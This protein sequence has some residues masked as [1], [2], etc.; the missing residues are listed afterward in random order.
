MDILYTLKHG[1]VNEEL[2]YSLRSLCNLPHDKV[3]FVGGC[4][5]NIN[6]N[7]IIHIP[8]EQKSTKWRNSTNNVRLACMDERLSDDFILMNDDFF[9]LEPI[10]DPVKELNVSGG[11]MQSVY[12]K[13]YEKYGKEIN[14]CKGMR[15]TRDL[16]QKQGIYNPLCYELHIPFIFNKSKFLAIFDIPGVQDINVLHKRSLYGNLHLKNTQMATDVKVRKEQ[17]IPVGSKFI[18]CSDKGFEVIKPILEKL[19]P[20]KSEYEQE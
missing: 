4:P 6:K 11:T 13:V 18:S 1:D 12:D 9:I 14:W 3:F 19:F 7:K 16:L 17:E 5:S 8:V 2:T 10:A 20:Q 15:E